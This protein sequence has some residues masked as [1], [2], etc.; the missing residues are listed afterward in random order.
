MHFTGHD[1]HNHPYP[2]LIHVISG[3]VDAHLRG[4]SSEPTHLGLTVGSSLW[5]GA[6]IDHSVTAKSDS[7]ML[8]PRL[9]PQTEPPEGFLHIRHSPALREVALRIL[10][11]SPSSEVER[12]PLRQALDAELSAFAVDDFPIPEPQHRAVQAIVDDPMTLLVPLTAVAARHSMSRRHVER[13]VK[14]DLNLS[15]VQWRTRRRLNLALRRIRAGS[16]VASA[17]RAVGYA[18][19]DG[20]IKAVG[21]LTHLTR[22]ELSDDLAGAVRDSR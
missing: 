22:Q 2:L 17:A 1:W 13:I 14:D 6:G 18:G 10:A 4:R 7:I 8:G 20:L 21:R 15:F 9:S 16:T 5:L 19:S 3:S 11:S 12:I